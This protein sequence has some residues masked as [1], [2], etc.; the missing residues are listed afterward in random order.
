A[1][2]LPRSAVGSGAG[3][4]LT[5]APRAGGLSGGGTRRPR[6][7][8]ARLGCFSY[9]GTPS[10]RERGLAHPADY[11]VRAPEHRVSPKRRTAGVCDVDAGCE[12][13]VADRR[14]G[15][16]PE[17]SLD[18]PPGRPVSRR[19]P[20]PS[21]AARVPDDAVAGEHPEGPD[22]VGWRARFLA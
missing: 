21:L 18:S 17:R 22:V 10:I 3:S 2:E 12:P 7:A 16:G 4:C 19:L 20:L 1:R 6:V 8:G 9:L 11:V 15:G 5:A 14:N 13:P